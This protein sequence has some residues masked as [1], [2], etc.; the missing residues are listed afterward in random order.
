MQSV[1]SFYFSQF[2]EIYFEF[3]ITKLYKSNGCTIINK[4]EL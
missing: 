1:M 2:F 4:L 3:K